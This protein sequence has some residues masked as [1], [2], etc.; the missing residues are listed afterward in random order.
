MA[1]V[2]R[3]HLAPLFDGRHFLAGELRTEPT[4][5]VK[6]SN[7]GE[8]HVRNFPGSV[9]RSVDGRVVDA[10]ELAVFR[11]LHV[12]LKAQ[13]KLKACSEIRKRVLRGVQ[14]QAAVADDQRA[15]RFGGIGVGTN[16]E[17]ANH[18]QKYFPDV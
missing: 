4:T 7:L 5:G 11:P 16:Y 9:R 3:N 1:S 12:E 18:R 6:F 2:L 10:N 13:A 8:G 15:R 14:Q 17:L